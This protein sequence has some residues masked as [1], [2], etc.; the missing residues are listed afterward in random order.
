MDSIW[1]DLRASGRPPRSKEEID[2]DLATNP[3]HME[4]FG[5]G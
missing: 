5:R 4:G 3:T 1:A 2:A